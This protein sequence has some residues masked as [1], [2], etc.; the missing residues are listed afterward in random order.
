ML[1]RAARASGLAGALDTG[2]QGQFLLSV[3]QGPA[4]FAEGGVVGGEGVVDAELVVLPRGQG[5]ELFGE[6][7]VLQPDVG[8]GRWWRAWAPTGW[9]VAGSRS[10]TDPS[11]SAL[12]SSLPLD[13]DGPC[14][15]LPGG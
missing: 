11:A 12:A 2:A 8:S 3:G 7:D 4:E 15:P 1:S 5:R 9:P 10:R 13:F 6:Q 14:G